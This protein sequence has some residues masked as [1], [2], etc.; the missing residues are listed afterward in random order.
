MPK[1]TV[2]KEDFSPA[3]LGKNTKKVATKDEA[4][5]TKKPA[6]KKVTT[7]KTGKNSE[8]VVQSSEQNLQS[9][10]LKSSE[11]LWSWWGFLSWLG[12]KKEEKKSEPE[13]ETAVTTSD[14]FEKSSETPNQPRSSKAPYGRPTFSFDIQQPKKAE[15]RNYPSSSPT[16][17]SR[18]QRFTPHGAGPAQRAA[19]VPPK[20]APIHGGHQKPQGYRWWSGGYQGRNRPAPYKATGWNQPY[21]P[22]PHT[23][24]PATNI[25]HI[26]KIEKAATTSANLV[27]KATIAIDEQIT[28]KEFSEKMGIPL[29]QVMKALLQNKIMK[30]ITASLD[31]DTASLIA[32]DL[33]VA[34]TKK[35]NKLGV[36]TFM[37]GN[38][39]AILDLDKETDFSPSWMGNLL[40]R[41]PIVTIMGHV[42]HGKTSLLD[43][44][45]KTEV[46]SGEAGGITQSIWASMINYNG[47]PITFIDTPWHELFT[48]LR[49]RWAKLTNIAVIVIAADDSVMP[50]TVE[51]IGHAKAAGV[52][53]IIA[54]TKID[55][56]GNK[57]DQ[58]KTDIAKHWLTAEDRWGDVPVIGISSKTGQGIPQLLE[59]I[60]LQAEILEL[61][62]N[63]KRSAVGVILDANKDPKQGVVSTVIVM[64]GTLKVGDIVV[65]YNTYGKVRRMKDRKGQ[66]ITEVTGGE[67][68]QLLGITDL[69]EPGRIIEVVKNEKE[70]QAKIALIK[71]QIK[72][73]SP[74]SA[75]QQFIAG[76]KSGN[77]EAE[78]RLIL[79]SDGSSSLEA[80]QQAIN[81]IQLPKNVTIKV[82][83]SEA[84]YFSQSDLSLAQ[85]SWALLIGFNIT[86]N[87][88]L[89]KKAESM[90]IEMRNYDIIYELTDYIQKLV[91]GMVEIEMAEAVTGKL[92]VLGIFFAKA[93]EMVI[94][95]KV[96]SGKVKNKSKFRILRTDATTKDHGPDTGEIIVANG[97]IVSLHKNKDEVKEMYEGEECG[98]KVHSGKRIEIGDTLE[99]YEMQEVL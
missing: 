42:D 68:V 25:S 67:P 8:E 1:V 21:K 79:K 9:S 18:P 52:P 70:A 95:G 11:I 38:L 99:F 35:E 76:L 78:L 53:I 23:P 73:R 85:A 90:K 71:E 62:Y 59:Q 20:A 87:T 15:A 47:K 17:D 49:A 81:G 91:N 65:A 98:M 45:R 69:P 64:T 89:K 28:V 5:P 34:V 75:V 61:K 44:L 29:P 50:Q 4:K 57:I 32:A 55:K 3:R 7:K 6:A 19:Y 77:K 37:S 93:K 10:V 56:P 86:I 14:I 58:I 43:Y 31:F 83:H 13:E 12:F 80:L 46:A 51:S 39:Q 96:L 72:K 33:G 92:E 88:I 36:E 60:L 54:I 40:P 48:S 66:N 41:A 74:Q 63:P 27:K 97:E 24:H 82:I 2:K 22:Y 16:R 26:K 84:G 94:G 30:G